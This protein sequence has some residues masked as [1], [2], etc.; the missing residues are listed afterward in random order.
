LCSLVD[1]FFNY[2]TYRNVIAYGTKN[3]G[4]GDQTAA[5]QEAINDDS[6]GGNRYQISLAAQPARVSIPGGTYTLGSKLDLRKG[7]IIMRDP[8]N[9]P[10]LK[11]ASGFSAE[12]LVDGYDSASVAETFFMTQLRNVVI[13]TTGLPASQTIGAL[14]WGVA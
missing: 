8:Q 6:Q 7:T 14:R 4:S 10:I 1:N 3:D 11:A 9:Q 2:K 12:S 13:D 5:I